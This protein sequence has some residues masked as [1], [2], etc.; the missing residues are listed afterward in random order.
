MMKTQNMRDR[1]TD[2]KTVE[3]KLL[4]V[5]M[6]IMVVVLFA[7]AVAVATV[8]ATYRTSTINFRLLYLSEWMR[9]VRD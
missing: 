3:P 1:T 2:N 7:A 4:F 6:V 8:A 5:I 9:P